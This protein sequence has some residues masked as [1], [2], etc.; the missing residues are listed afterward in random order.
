MDHTDM[1]SAMYSFLE[2]AGQD[3]NDEHLRDT[4][5]RVARAY[6]ELL[7]PE[8]FNFT[9][10]DNG[11]DYDQMV[12]QTGIRFTSLCAHHLLS[13]SGVAH[14][15]YIPHTQY[16]GL[17]KLAR[18][19]EYFS[20]RLQIQERLTS[21]VGNFLQEKLSPMGVA[22]IITATHSCMSIR[23]AKQ[24]DAATT[25]SYIKGVFMSSPPAR[26]ELMSLIQL[27]GPYE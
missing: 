1:A 27:G 26:A 3:M 13:F 9:T 4:P 20:R 21:Q 10:F 16:V 19:V 22:V 8:E 5:A 7:T 23:G 6:Q 24:P 17:S 15:A 2:A 18:C 11:E 25:T 14:V 12:L